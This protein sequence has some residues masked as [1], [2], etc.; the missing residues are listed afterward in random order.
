MVRQRG[1]HFA[2]QD[3]ASGHGADVIL[4][5]DVAAHLEPRPDRCRVKVRARFER[6]R[7]VRRAVREQDVEVDRRD[8]V[9]VADLD[10]LYASAC[11]PQPLDR[12]LEF[13]PHLVV[14]NIAKVPAQD[15][16]THARKRRRNER[17]RREVA[18][19]SAIHDVRIA[20]G[21]RQRA[22]VIQSPRQ[23]HHAVGRHFSQRR[24]ES[25]NAACS[26]WYANRSSGVASNR[27]ER[28]ACS[29]A[30]RRAGGPEGRLFVRRSERELVKVGLPDEHRAGLAKI[31]DRRRIAVRDVPFSYAR[32]GRG[33]HAA[34]VDDV[35][36]RDRHAVQRAAVVPRGQ[37][38][39]GFLRPATRL[40]RGDRDERVEPRIIGVDPAQARFEGFDRRRLARPQPA[41]EFLDGDYRL[42]TVDSVTTVERHR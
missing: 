22:D 42:L 30:D 31:H 13:G 26:G 16:E 7:V 23:R 6:F 36:D 4:G 14:E 5:E 15:S 39:V 2:A 29:D 25:D 33:R 3:G 12:A 28:H 27:S 20:D 21:R 41:S 35:F 38:A 9:G 10:L 34:H 8:A 24:L 32:S 1:V 40:V 11:R 17:P 37:L 18:G 19:Q